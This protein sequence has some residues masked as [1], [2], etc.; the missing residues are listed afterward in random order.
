MMTPADGGPLLG[1]CFLE[2]DDDF[3]PCMYGPG[4]ANYGE[5]FLRCVTDITA[6]DTEYFYG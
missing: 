4:D 5:K 2:S 3:G 6:W 1:Q